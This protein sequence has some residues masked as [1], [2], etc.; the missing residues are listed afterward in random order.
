MTR[1]CHANDTQTL[2]SMFL[3][4][5]LSISFGYFH[6]NNNLF[7]SLRSSS[8]SLC[9]LFPLVCPYQ[10]HLQSV[11]DLFQIWNSKIIQ[12][13]TPITITHSRDKELPIVYPMFSLLVT[14]GGDASGLMH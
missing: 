1:H 4:S 6:N 9:V 12:Q 3:F 8:P 5:L 14:L 7:P 2:L 10:D 11:Y 13:R